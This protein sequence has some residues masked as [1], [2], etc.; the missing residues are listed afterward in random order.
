MKLH[1]SYLLQCPRILHVGDGDTSSTLRISSHY[2]PKIGAPPMP[3]LMR[4]EQIVLRGCQ[5]SCSPL[6]LFLFN[7]PCLK[8]RKHLP[9][10][11]KSELCRGDNDGGGTPP[12]E[13]EVSAEGGTR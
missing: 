8:F 1:G 3:L 13:S 9:P 12:V 11:L 7:A 10:S 5:A 4:L 6:L 2:S